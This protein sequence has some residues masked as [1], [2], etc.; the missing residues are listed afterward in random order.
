MVARVV[1]PVVLLLSTLVLPQSGAQKTAL[2]TVV[3]DAAGPVR[4]LSAKDFIVREDNATREV[5]AAS[6]SDDPLSIAVLLDTTRPPMGVQYP[7]QDVRTAMSTFG[8]TVLAASPG[9]QIALMQFAGASVTKV[10]FTS[11]G[12]ELDKVIQRLYPDL[13]ATSVLL[14]GLADAG[15]KLS[16]RPAPRRAI[17][18]IDLNSPEASTEQ[19]MKVAIESIHNAGATLWAVSVRGTAPTVAI[20]EE[21]LNKVTKANGGLRLSSVDATGLEGMLKSVANSLASQ[22]VVTFTRPNGSSPKTTEFATTRG[23]KVL[24]T[25]FMR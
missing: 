20:R 23:A 19:M 10:D 9:A 16:A 12:G 6:A 18:S 17:V 11:N 3:A 22:Y 1:S 24:L 4:D 8:K 2:V 7:I 25:P 5:V 14:E 15:K 13:Q 21:V